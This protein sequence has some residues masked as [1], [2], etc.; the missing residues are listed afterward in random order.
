MGR[1]GTAS[2]PGTWP[3]P[4]SATTRSSSTFSTTGSRP[5]RVT[6]QFRGS[7]ALL[8]QLL[9]VGDVWRNEHKR[10][11]AGLGGEPEPGASAHAGRPLTT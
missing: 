11:R 8:R 5:I 2:A 4:G 3:G 1:R 10:F 6:T 9:V 7:V